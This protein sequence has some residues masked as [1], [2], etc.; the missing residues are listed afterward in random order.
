MAIASVQSM[1]SA[2]SQWED[3]L[4]MWKAVCRLCRWVLCP[5]WAVRLPLGQSME[6]TWSVL[7]LSSFAALI[8]LSPPSERS[9]WRRYCFCLMCLCVC[10]CTADRSIIAPKRLQLQTS[11]LTSMFPGTVQT[12]ALK[13]FRIGARWGSRDSHSSLGVICS[14]TVKLRTSN[15]TSVFPGTVRIWPLKMF[16]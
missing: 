16:F 1:V 13:I 12:W 2:C 4:S 7:M 5:E 15:L 11:Y 9:E 3:L 6:E 8:L 10:V 14:K